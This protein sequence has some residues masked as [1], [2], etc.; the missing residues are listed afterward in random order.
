MSK[1]FSLQVVFADPRIRCSATIDAASLDEAKQKL[2]EKLKDVRQIS[3]GL[4]ESL[5]YEAKDQSAS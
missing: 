3:G 4:A 2:E 1:Q 5:N